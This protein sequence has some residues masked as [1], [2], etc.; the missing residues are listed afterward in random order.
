[1]FFANET[2]LVTVTGTRRRVN[3][4]DRKTG[5]LI[6]SARRQADILFS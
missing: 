1:L 6:A 5:G 3:L 4:L 2:R